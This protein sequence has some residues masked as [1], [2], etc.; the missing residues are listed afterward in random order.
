[1]QPIWDVSLDKVVKSGRPTIAIPLVLTISKRKTLQQDYFAAT[2]NPI[3]E[4]SGLEFNKKEK[5]FL[6]VK[7]VCRL[8][9]VYPDCRSHVVPVSYMFTGGLFYVASDYG[10]RKLKNIQNNNR[11]SLVVDTVRP[12]RAVVVEGEASLV[13]RGSDFKEIYKMFY[14]SFSWVRRDPWSEGEAPFIVV[15]PIRKSSWG[16]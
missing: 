13:E 10:T 11:V 16:L 12:N 15:K 3:A 14:G 6:E 2:A 1:M 8:A 7:E 4:G 9:T 5:R